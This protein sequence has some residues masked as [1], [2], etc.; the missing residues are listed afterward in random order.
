MKCDICKEEH[1]GFIAYRISKKKFGV[2]CQ[3]CFDKIKR[4]GGIK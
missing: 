1:K 4:T 3:K 2:A